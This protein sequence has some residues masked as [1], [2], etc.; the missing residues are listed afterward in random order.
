MNEFKELEAD[1]INLQNQ[2]DEFNEWFLQLEREKQKEI[3][4][5]NKKIDESAVLLV[6]LTSEKCTK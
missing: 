3:D 2:L 5:L 1:Q 4:D 6:E